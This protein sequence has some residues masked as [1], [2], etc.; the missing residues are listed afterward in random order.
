MEGTHM[1]ARKATCRLEAVADALLGLV[2][3]DP[4]F[5][6]ALTHETSKF[7]LKQK[8]LRRKMISNLYHLT[9]EGT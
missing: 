2:N 7:M 9:S 8:T 3:I 1:D 6:Q 4:F 5:F